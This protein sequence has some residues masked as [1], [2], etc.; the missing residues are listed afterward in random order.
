MNPETSKEK[1]SEWQ[2]P[3]KLFVHPLCVGKL[4]RVELTKDSV[5]IESSNEPL[6]SKETP[7]TS[8]EQ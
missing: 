7:N 6:Y 5:E 2:E 3:V 4:T 8:K 1:F